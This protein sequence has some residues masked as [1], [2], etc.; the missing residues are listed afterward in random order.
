MSI[1]KDFSFRDLT[2]EMMKLYSQGDMVAALELVDRHAG[3]FPERSPLINFWRICLLSLLGRKDQALDILGQALDQGL[4]WHEDQFVDS[5]LDTVRELPEFKRLV[6]LSHERY[7]QA[8]DH[9]QRDRRILLPS[10]VSGTLPLLIALHGRNGNAETDL[11]RW[12]AARQRGWLVL[13]VQSTQPLS[14]YSYF[15][16]DPKLGL[17]DIRFHYEEITRHH[18]IDRS[19]VVLA[20]FS[21]GAGMALLGALEGSIPA[22][23]F[24]GIASWWEEVE[25]LA[26]LAAH[27]PKLR[28]YFVT[29][30]NDHTFE[31]SR[32][33][34]AALCAHNIP[35]AEELHTGLGHEFPPNFAASF[36][37][38]I[39]F[40]LEEAE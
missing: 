3:A 17:A 21:Q 16:D 27:A 25:E 26:A 2:Q 23:G 7:L 20:G 6:R 10:K 15:W 13:S 40:I 5:D 29:G 9:T 30:E 22:R 1:E 24:I 18:D 31:R 14:S 4:W 36:D 12:E 33:I 32:D 37:K 8:R 39:A 34:Q 35:L 28:T 11:E 38:A 19:R